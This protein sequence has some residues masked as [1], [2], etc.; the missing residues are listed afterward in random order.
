MNVESG[1]SQVKE[2]QGGDVAVAG[3]SLG[4]SLDSF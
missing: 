4:L 3:R 1:K 2:K